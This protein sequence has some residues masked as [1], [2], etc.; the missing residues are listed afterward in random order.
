MYHYKN[1][2]EI[3]NANV[4]LGQCW[5]VGTRVLPAVIDGRYFVTSEKGPH[6]PRTYTVREAQEDGSIETVGE[7]MGHSTSVQA[8]NAARHEAGRVRRHADD[9]HS[10]CDARNCASP[11]A[12]TRIVRES[13]RVL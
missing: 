1:I 12:Q 2:T 8:Q 13:A 9:D 3:K 6:G 7:F 4:K 5:F 10:M 11:E